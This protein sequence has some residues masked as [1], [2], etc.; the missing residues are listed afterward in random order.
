MDRER[1]VRRAFDRFSNKDFVGVVN[2]MDPDVRV[3]DL[4]RPG[5]E[6]YGRDAVLL[7]WIRRFDEARAEAFVA[8]VLGVG[9][10][11]LAAVC[12]QAYTAD[13]TPFGAP[14]IVASRFTFD[15]DGRIT[16]LRHTPFNDVRDDVKA[17]FHVR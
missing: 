14:F 17:L 13:D 5:Q 11:A 1:L 15:E 16:R 2:L 12:F 4:L 6:W 7:Q 10:T 8:D 3:S 9:D